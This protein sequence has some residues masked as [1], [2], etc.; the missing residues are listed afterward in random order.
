MKK[1][2]EL[3]K[4]VIYASKF[5]MSGLIFMLVLG[6]GLFIFIILYDKFVNPQLSVALWIA[7]I[8]MMIV[9]PIIAFILSAN[10]GFLRI[11]IDEKGIK[12][13]LFHF[14]RKRDFLWEDLKEIACYSM[15]YPFIIFSKSEIPDYMPYSKVIRR[16]DVIT[17]QLNRKLYKAILRFTDKPISYLSEDLI[18]FLKLDK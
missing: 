17:V 4:T 9:V 11:E 14:F 12:T 3:N 1:Q 7:L 5:I 8:L 15:I 10:R 16:K 13:S 6:S 18:D 2:K